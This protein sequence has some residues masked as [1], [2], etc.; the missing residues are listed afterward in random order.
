MSQIDAVFRQGLALFMGLALL[1]G[2]QS[3]SAADNFRVVTSIKPLHSIL[4]GLMAGTEGPEL[5]LD[6][7]ATP[8]G[9]HL[10]PDQ[11]AAL[12]AADLIVWVGP[13]LERFM[14]EPVREAETSGRRVMTLLDNPELKILPP[15]GR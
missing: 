2:S 11:A 13:E 7:D 14:I 10:K 1:L 4:A 6:G 12:K 3:L 15:L 8:F 9:Y 5:L